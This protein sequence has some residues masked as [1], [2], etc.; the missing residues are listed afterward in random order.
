[1]PDNYYPKSDDV[2][3]PGDLLTG[4]DDLAEFLFGD[5][6]KRRQIYQMGSLPPGERPPLFHVG[7]LI[8]GRKSQLSAWM[9]ER[10]QAAAANAEVRVTM[11]GRLPRDGVRRR[12]TAVPVLQAPP[13]LKG[14]PLPPV[15]GSPPKRGQV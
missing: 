14:G 9:R 15:P 10:E 4:G 8:A 1:M 3:P 6:R 13:P 12:T 2:I 11:L 7:A 5:K